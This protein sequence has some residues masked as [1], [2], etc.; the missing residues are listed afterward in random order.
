MKVLVSLSIYK[1][2]LSLGMT[3]IPVS[4]TN[5]ITSIPQND[6]EYETILKP[7]MSLNVSTPVVEDEVIENHPFTRANRR[8]KRA[9]DEENTFWEKDVGLTT[10]G[11]QASCG[12]CW[13][14]P[15]VR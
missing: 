6:A 14:F 11:D 2:Y 10:P 9:L 5:S 13:S 4:C 7:L 1:G 8:N 15:N 12:S 3:H